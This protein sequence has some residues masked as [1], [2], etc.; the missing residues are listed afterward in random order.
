MDTVISGNAIASG[1]V[2][3]DFARLKTLRKYSP[4]PHNE[5]QIGWPDPR[6]SA[7]TPQRLTRLAFTDPALRKA[8]LTSAI[9]SSA[10]Y[11]T[12]KIGFEF[13][14]QPGSIST[15]WM[16][17]SLV[18]ATLLLTDARWWWVMIA[19]T[20]PAH[21]ASELLSGVPVMMVLSWFVSNSAQALLGAWLLRYWIGTEINFRRA[22][23]L[24]AFFICGAFLAPFL[25]SFLDSAL[26]KLN[27]LGSPPYWDIWRLR[28]LSNV[29]A[30]L[31][32]VPFI[33]EW[34]Q[35]GLS[36]V[37]QATFSRFIEG[38]VLMSVL[39]A[40]GVVVFNTQQSTFQQAPAR[41][42]WP[43]P[44]LVWAAIRFGI[45]GV[46]TGLLLVMFLA[47][48][49]ATHG[50]GPFLAGSSSSHNALS[51][52]AFLVLI[53][54]PLLMLAAVIEERQVTE[55]SLRQSEKRLLLGTRKIRSLAAQLITAQES[56]R[57]RIALLLHDDVGQ[58]VAALG[59][60]ISRLKRRAPTADESFV[61][62]LDRLGSQVN[63]LTTQ[64]RQLSHQLHPEVL[65]HVGLIAALES[66]FAEL[67]QDKSMRVSFSANVK[68][69]PIPQDVAACLYRVA[70]EAV[71]NVSLHSGA[72]SA[73]VGLAEAEGFLVLEVSDSGRGFDLEKVRRGSGLGLASS[74]ERVRLLNGS[75]E[76]RSNPQIGTCLTARVPLMRA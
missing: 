55:A 16:P 62:D 7:M 57:R 44:I 64:V 21:V 47:I 12:A 36:S 41:L 73:K 4:D 33:V 67:D 26:V 48:Y 65:D 68:T 56:E 71:R 22:R 37:K 19:A 45:R 75:L 3:S 72:R 50:S 29:L 38:G 23:D 46:T 63:S 5:I 42:Y 14:L 9:L 31:I 20:L 8:L 66:H 59:L 61:A 17:N 25:S 13:T 32:L 15:L 2:L 52:Q 10:Y 74:E 60:A 43:L 27:A 6:K 76:I 54:V 11:I 35:E 40:V 30:T 58:N 69:D 39:F 34:V 53:A 18:L 28:F 51:I 49:G 24:T 70:L 1:F